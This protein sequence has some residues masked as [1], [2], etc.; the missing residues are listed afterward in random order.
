M[1]LSKHNTR[2]RAVASSLTS[3]PDI[4][5]TTKLVI[6]QHGDEA[7]VFA[8]SRADL[9]LEEGDIDGAAV[10]RWILAAIEE[11]QRGR[12]EDDPIN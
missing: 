5:R 9:L 10:W 11:L 12:R 2:L 3:D 6:D 4:F 1:G 8:A 7:A